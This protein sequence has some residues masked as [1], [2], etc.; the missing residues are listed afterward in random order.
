MTKLI[1]LPLAD[2][3][4][5]KDC[6]AE[7]VRRCQSCGHGDGSGRCDFPVSNGDLLLAWAGAAQDRPSSRNYAARIA[8]KLPTLREDSSWTET[9]IRLGEPCAQY[10]PGAS[11]ETWHNNTP[12]GCGSYGYCGNCGLV[13]PACTCGVYSY[14]GYCGGVLP[15][16][17]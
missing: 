3:K 6:A 14:C 10:L 12:C 17:K 13:P 16:A 8:S 1:G 2:T 15:P 7:F 9:W 4:I 11:A 5:I